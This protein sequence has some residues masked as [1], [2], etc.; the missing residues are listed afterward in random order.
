MNETKGDL[1]PEEEARRESLSLVERS[2]IAFLG[3]VDELG[4]PH[5]KGMFKARSSGIG[6][7]W[8]STNTSSERVGHICALSKTCVYFVDMEN[9]AGLMLVGE[10]EATRSEEARRMIWEEGDERYYPLG[11]DDPDFTVLHFRAHEGNFY[12]KLRKC[13]FAVDIRKKEG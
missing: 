4:Y 13:S 8:F 6:E 1:M 3:T 7:V 11:I 2:R 5:I 10:T 9:I 12:H